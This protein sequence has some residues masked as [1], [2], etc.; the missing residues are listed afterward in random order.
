MKSKGIAVNNTIKDILEDPHFPEGTAWKQYHFKPEEIIIN[1][2]F[3]ATPGSVGSTLRK[4]LNYKR[5][6]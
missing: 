4:E 5:V 1:E 6:Y 3:R 2:G